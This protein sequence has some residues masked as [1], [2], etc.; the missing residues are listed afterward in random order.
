MRQNILSVIFL[1][2]GASL[3][4]AIPVV[5][6]DTVR[7]TVVYDNYVHQEGT[8]GDWGFGCFIEGYE[9]TILFDTGLHGNILLDNIDTLSIDLGTL[10]AIVISHNHGDHTG[11]LGSV[12]GRNGKVT[13]YMGETYSQTYHPFISAMRGT[14][15]AVDEPIEI[16]AHVYSTGEIEGSIEEQS[17]ILDTDDGLVVV[18]GCSHPGVDNMVRRAKEVLDKDIYLVFGGF[19]LGGHSDAEVNQIIQEFQELGVEYCGA[20]HCTGDQA[21]SLFAQAYGDH[22]IPIGVGKVFEFT[23]SEDV[24]D[25]TDGDGIPDQG[26][27]CPGTPNPDQEDDDGDGAGDACDNCQGISN[28]DQSDADGDGS[29][30]GCDECTDSDGDGYGDPGFETNTCDEDNCPEVS[31][32][33]QEAVETG[34]IDCKGEIDVLDVLAVVNHILGENRVLGASYKRADCN[35]DGDVNILDAVGIINVILGTGSCEL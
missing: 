31:N 22:Y 6:A 4:T 2:L 21:I 34:N 18:T 20:T 25:D 26:D 11:G 1:M 19:H 27:N 7:L 8:T 16:C 23:L 10:D 12:L 15:V 29:G 24:D 17:L 32:P 28:P 3:F 5:A 14:V 33:G 13:V 9:K 30:D 35:A